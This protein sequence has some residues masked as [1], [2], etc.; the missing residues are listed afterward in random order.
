[1]EKIKT[2][3]KET[4]TIYSERDEYKSNGFY[5]NRH[6]FIQKDF[7]KGS[8]FYYKKNYNSYSFEFTIAN[9]TFNG[10]F[11]NK[12]FNKYLYSN[13]ELRKLK[14]KQLNEENK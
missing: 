13:K 7:I 6:H 10:Y 8:E 3:V 11:D 9:M 5:I 4:F 2:Y 1:M 14:I 12:E